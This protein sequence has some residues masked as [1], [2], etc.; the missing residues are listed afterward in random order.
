[1]SSICNGFY[2]PTI[3]KIIRYKTDNQDDIY[4][5]IFVGHRSKE[6]QKIL[7]VFISLYLDQTHTNRDKMREREISRRF[8]QLII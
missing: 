7:L 2:N 3:Y 8:F 1:M 6:I 4:K 5:Y